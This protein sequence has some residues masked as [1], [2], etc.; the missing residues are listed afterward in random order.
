MRCVQRATAGI[1]FSAAALFAAI[2]AWAGS[3]DRIAQ[4]GKMT[5]AVRDDAPPFAFIDENGKHAGFSVDLCRA[6]AA[7]IAAR[8]GRDITVDFLPITAQTRLD[9]VTGGTADIECG[10]TTVTL[11]RRETV[12]FSLPFFVTGTAIAVPADSAARS[13]TDLANARIAVVRDTTTQATMGRLLK[14]EGVTAEIVGVAR[15]GDAVAAVSA[16][17]ADALASDRMVLIG[18][19]DQASGLRL[20]P[21]LMSYEPYA[22]VLPRG[23]ADFRLEVDRALIEFYKEGVLADLYAEW[24]GPTGARPGETLELMLQLNAVPE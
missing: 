8:V 5:L 20:M 12:D 4:T 15:I 7:D 13:V 10:I 3:L 11:S 21:G 16:G 23:D 6:L 2:P 19:G 18:L 17:E 9:A 1:L 22:L 24:L 14:E